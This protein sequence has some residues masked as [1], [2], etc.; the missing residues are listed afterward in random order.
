MGGGLLLVGVGS[1]P[2]VAQLAGDQEYDPH[3]R[4][5]GGGRIGQ[6]VTCSHDPQ[7][8]I[9]CLAATPSC[10]APARNHATEPKTIMA[11]AIN[12]ASLRPMNTRGLI[13]TNSTMK[14]AT[15]AS[16]K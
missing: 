4:D 14:R 7:A 2:I 9:A 5:Y 3:Q 12:W 10:L 11:I 16:M 1:A 8:C 15:P 6:F 13:R